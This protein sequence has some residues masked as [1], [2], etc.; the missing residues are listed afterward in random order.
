MKIES[1]TI[2]LVIMNLD[3]ASRVEALARL[4]EKS[5][6]EEKTYYERWGHSNRTCLMIMKYTIDKSIRQSITCNNSAKDFL[7]F[8]F[9]YF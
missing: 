1:L 9:I 7:F 3:L 6:A 2:N 4:I 5:S 8:I